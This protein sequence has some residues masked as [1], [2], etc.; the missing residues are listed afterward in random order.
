MNKIAV[1]SLILGGALLAAPAI[2]LA[3]PPSWAHNG[4]HHWKHQEYR[5]DDRGRDRDD[6][7]DNERHYRHHW[8][9]G[10]RHHDNRVIY[11]QPLAA[12][13]YRHAHV[14]QRLPYGYRLPSHARIHH[15]HSGITELVVA[16]QIIRILDAT[17][18]IVNVSR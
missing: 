14:G 13:W 15:L 12:D 6:D 8:R 10:Y 16:D 7:R 11:V 3:D 1:K 18:T 4:G 5:H 9:H 2:T 17:Q